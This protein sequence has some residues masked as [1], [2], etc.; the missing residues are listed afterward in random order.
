[1]FGSN[2]TKINDLSFI[3]IILIMLGVLLMIKLHG[4]SNKRAKSLLENM[5]YDLIKW[6]VPALG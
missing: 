2:A 6:L 4:N 1:M 5:N 3:Y